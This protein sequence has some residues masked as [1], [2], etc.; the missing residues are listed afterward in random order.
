[1]KRKILSTLANLITS[2]LI[3]GELTPRE[4]LFKKPACMAIKISPNAERLA[5]VGSD[6]EGT[7][8][9]FVTSSL[10]L[11]NAQQM[12][13]FAEPA[14]KGFYWLPDNKHVLLLKDTNGTGQFRLYSIN[15]DSKE[16]NDLTA[17]YKS[18][19][20]KVFYVSQTECKAVI[21]INNRNPKFH[22]LYL[23]DL[24]KGSLSQMYQNDQFINFVFDSN[25]NLVVKVRMN[26]DCSLTL[27]NKENAILFDLSAEDAFHTECLKFDHQEMALYLLDNRGCNTTQLKKICIDTGLE[28]ILGQNPLSDITDV[29]FENDKPVLY[30]TYYTHQEWHPLNNA[31]QSDISFLTAQMGPN[32]EILDQSRDSNTWILKNNIPDQGIEFWL[33][34]RSKKK[35]SLLFSYPG[36]E[37]LAK[38]HSLVIP[39]QDGLNLVSYLTLPK[40]MDQGG[41][42][43]KPLPLVVFPHGGPFKLRDYYKYSPYHQWLANRGYAVL[44]VNFRLSS[45]FGKDF[46]NAGNGQWGRKAH[47]DVID[48]VNWCID[49]KIADKS[50]IAILGG[51]YG[52]YEALAGL[53]FTPEVFACAVAICGP[54]N[55]KTVLNT[56]PFYW[57]FPTAP[58]SDKMMYFTKN[59]FIKSMGGNPDNE[60]E[61]PYLQ[62]CSPLNYVDQIQ[63]PLLLVHGMNDPIVAV[64]ESDQIF[65]KMKQKNL[66]VTYISFP[67]EGHHIM[68]T[69][70]V[71]CYLAHA[72]WLLAQFLGGRYESISQDQI[73]SSSA[74]IR[75]HSMSPEKASLHP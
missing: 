35:L 31:L 10:S 37:N 44:S 62:S 39:S 71:M 48:A 57:E 25:L 8:N 40:E 6:R 19:N 74:I 34:S 14:I 36:I 59:A 9:L 13:H 70:N 56:V 55:L 63:R 73:R 52:G 1:M 54:S 18:I 69:D 53:T 7:M 27:L 75:S 68:K 30:S 32:F 58:L 15:L 49:A 42:P 64:S 22:D 5:Y 4:V 67:D 2:S 65:E 51:S 24:E 21:G 17:E 45:G 41:T 16:A 38:M 3:A 20:A 61:I 50:K 72:E 66:P 33:Y 26:E 46:V 12:T 43:K 11:D 28:E 60:N 47:R 23:L 29:Y